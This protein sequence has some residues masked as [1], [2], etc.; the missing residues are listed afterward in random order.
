[1]DTIDELL[2]MTSSKN[3]FPVISLLRLLL[4]YPIVFNRYKDFSVINQVIYKVNIPFDESEN[5]ELDTNPKKEKEEKS[6]DT[7]SEE[8]PEENISLLQ[9]ST[10]AT[11]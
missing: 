9:F 2:L 6:D 11:V 3:L 8:K 10:I 5:V 4:A 7:S 1:M